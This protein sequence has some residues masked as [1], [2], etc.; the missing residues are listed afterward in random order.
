MTGAL[1]VAATVLL[2]S[3]SAGAALDRSLGLGAAA[4]AVLGAAVVLAALVPLVR[5]H[6]SQYVTAPL[7]PLPSQPV[8]LPAGT[9]VLY[10]RGPHSLTWDL[11][12]QTIG[13]W[14]PVASQRV[15][16]WDVSPFGTRSSGFGTVQR[17]WKQ[18]EVSRP[19]EYVLAVGGLEEGR[20]YEDRLV[21]GTASPLKRLLL[22]GAIIVGS[23]TSLFAFLLAR[24]L[25]R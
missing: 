25:L 1:P 17:A 11:G 14:D 22:V 21:F 13:L 3:S 20:V 2:A 18:F 16:S 5:M 19:G 12:G 15:R 23:V 7:V 6:R 9:L 8:A 24:A 10:M 4:V